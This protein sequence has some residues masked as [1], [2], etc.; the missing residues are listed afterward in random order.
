MG[1]LGKKKG[2]VTKM[3]FTPAKDLIRRAYNFQNIYKGRINNTTG[4]TPRCNLTEFILNRGRFWSKKYPDRYD[5]F[6]FAKGFLER[7][8]GHD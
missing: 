5:H 3:R 4:K 2:R 8:W 7:K 6:L 1:C